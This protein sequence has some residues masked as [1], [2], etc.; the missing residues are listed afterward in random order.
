MQPLKMRVNLFVPSCRKT[1]SSP[2]T[3]PK[4]GPSLSPGPIGQREQA[5]AELSTAIEMYQAMTVTLGRHRC[6]RDQC[7]GRECSME[8]AAA[9]A[10][11][12]DW[13]TGVMV[14][15]PVPI[16]TWKRGLEVG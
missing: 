7:K 12:L 4:N 2:L 5:R 15:V 8:F 11:P 16:M 6:T 14:S 13:L 3:W 10:R 1:K 9:K